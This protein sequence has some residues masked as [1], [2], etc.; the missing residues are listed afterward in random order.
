MCRTGGPYC[1]E[2]KLSRPARTKLNTKRVS[3]L[4]K[5]IGGSHVMP[6]SDD[7]CSARARAQAFL[8]GGETEQSDFSHALRDISSPDGGAT[9]NAVGEVPTSG[10]CYSPFPERSVAFRPPRKN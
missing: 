9:I 10:F 3:R 6:V 1:Y 2:R 8:S 4:T 7:D 5:K